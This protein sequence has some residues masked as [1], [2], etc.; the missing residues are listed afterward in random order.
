M[1][2]LICIYPAAG[3]ILNEVQA[4]SHLWLNLC[5]LLLI[6]ICFQMNVLVIGSFLNACA[7]SFNNFDLSH[8]SN[9]LT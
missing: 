4:I 3:Y 2:I 6:F 8:I 7:I 5:F 1:G 9:K